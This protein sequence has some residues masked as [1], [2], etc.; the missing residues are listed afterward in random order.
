MTRMR[1]RIHTGTIWAISALVVLGLPA[2]S[3]VYW[4]AVLKA[5]V[6]PPDADA[7]IIP[8]IESIVLAGLLAPFIAFVT[9]LCVRRRLSLIDLLIWRDDRPI[10]SGFVTICAALPFALGLFLIKKELSA[11]PG[12]FGH[13]W[14]PYTVL[15]LV[16]L[17]V[18]RAA[19]LE[20]PK[21]GQPPTASTTQT[22]SA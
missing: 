1:L 14:L 6:L 9:W 11:P 2:T 18:M 17:V 19:A 13:W 5:G 10:L 12:W 22:R 15:V 3:W 21:S 8:M 20:K 7:V 4:P 16:W